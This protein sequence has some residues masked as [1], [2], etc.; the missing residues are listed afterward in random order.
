MLLRL[1]LDVIE[2][3]LGFDTISRRIRLQSVC[4]AFACTHPDPLSKT[5]TFDLKK[6]KGGK[7]RCTVVRIDWIRNVGWSLTTTQNG[8]PPKKVNL[9]A[10]FYKGGKV[11]NDVFVKDGQLIVP[12]SRWS[13][14]LFHCFRQEILG[15]EIKPISKRSGS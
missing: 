1:P 8:S 14:P 11:G 6:R 10:D 13:I 2:H 4:K 15:L 3:I 12:W 7:V 9:P 5:L